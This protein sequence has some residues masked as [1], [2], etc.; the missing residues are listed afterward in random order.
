[1]SDIEKFAIKTHLI[2]LTTNLSQHKKY[3]LSTD[4]NEIIVPYIYLESKGLE[5][6]EKHIIEKA[7]SLVFVSELELL[8]QLISL[9]S[10]HIP[11]S[12]GEINT[13][14]GFVISKVDNLNDSYWIEF[15][16]FTPNKYSNI[17]FETVQKL[18]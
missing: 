3:I 4:P 18:K 16:Y 14:Y 1:M 9:H 10:E 15:D 2:I 7:Q 12:Q 17:I 5:N 8:P 11:P 6:L 13:V